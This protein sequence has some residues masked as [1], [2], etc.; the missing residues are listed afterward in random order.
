M[1]VGMSGGELFTTQAALFSTSSWKR[2]LFFVSEKRFVLSF[3]T[4]VCSLMHNFKLNLE[5]RLLL[6]LLSF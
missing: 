2:T 5:V 6:Q 3:V 1:T 4:P